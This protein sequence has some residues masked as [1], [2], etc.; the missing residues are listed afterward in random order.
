MARARIAQ[1][2]W[3]YLSA[4]EHPGRKFKLHEAMADTPDMFIQL[5]TRLYRPR[6]P[7]DE[8]QSEESKED[9]A[10]EAKVNW[11]HNA[12]RLL[13]TWKVVPGTQADGRIDAEK[14]RTWV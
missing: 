1:L 8:A 14:M 4:L 13:F 9:V 11:A 2:E 12:Y 7:D 5:L 3:S 6:V 10:D